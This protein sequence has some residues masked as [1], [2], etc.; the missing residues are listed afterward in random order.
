MPAALL[1]TARRGAVVAAPRGAAGRLGEQRLPCCPMTDLTARA[2]PGDGLDWKC[3][4]AGLPICRIR[5]D[6]TDSAD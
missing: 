6:L 1:V 2:S 5:F 3:D 4:V